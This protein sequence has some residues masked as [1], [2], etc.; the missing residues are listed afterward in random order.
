MRRALSAA[1]LTAAFL[2]PACNLT[3]QARVESIKQMNEGIT[4]LNKNN[5]SGAERAMQEAIKTDPTH[6]EAYLNLGKLYRKQQKWIDAEKAF[7][8]A[9]ENMGE[10]P[11]GDYW[12]ELGS[13][14]VS[15]SNEPGTSRAEQEEMWREAITSFSEA[16]KINP[17]LYRAHSQMG[18]LHEKLDEPEK[19]DQAFRK[20]IELNGK[21]SPCFV[22]LGN[23]YIDYGFSPEATAVLETGTK[24][25][26]TDADMWNG[27]G[28]ALLN[29]NRPKDAVE[30]YKKAKRIAPEKPDVLFGL[31][32]AYAEIPQ[33]KEAEET[34]QEFLNKAGNSPEHIKKAAQDTIMRMQGP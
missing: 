12:F 6:A 19:A 29:L 17:N 8:G 24:V 18:Q 33:R 15:K 26:E 32:M 28:R 10:T 31:G 21:Y 23:M 30:A 5:I 16:I 13:V 25:N 22:S 1:L 14:Q 4:Q 11:R 7:R 20:C 2:L 27:M 3:S 34:L 9:I